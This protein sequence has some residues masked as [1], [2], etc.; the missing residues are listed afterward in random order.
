MDYHINSNSPVRLHG[1]HTFNFIFNILKPFLEFNLSQSKT[2]FSVPVGFRSLTLTSCS[3]NSILSGQRMDGK[4]QHFDRVL[5]F[6]C[7][8]N[9]MTN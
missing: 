5:S 9:N 7:D 3:R 6:V 8:V 2:D 4:S 1:L